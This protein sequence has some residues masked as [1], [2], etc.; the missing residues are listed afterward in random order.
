MTHPFNSKK[1]WVGS[2]VDYRIGDAA[3]KALSEVNDNKYW[4]EGLGSIEVDKERWDQAQKYEL[5]TWM[6]HGTAS[7]DDRD[8]VHIEGFNSYV[9][10]PI[11]LGK[12]VEIG[13][14]P[15]TQS[16][17]IVQ[18]RTVD[19]VTLVDP[20]IL[21]YSKHQNCRYWSFDKKPIMVNSAAEDFT[22]T[23]FD[24]AICI[25]VL[26]HVRDANL[27]MNNLVKCLN[28]G[29]L[30]IFHDRVYDGLDITRIYDIGHPI[31]ITSAFLNP[32]L[33]MFKKVYQNDDYF[34]G[35]KNG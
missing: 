2:P 21:K 14:G 26:E 30:L 27:V 25:N 35:I 32:F 29:G 24:T 19:S 22:E 1:Q 5:D 4:R 31:R 13:C 3:D 18:G 8:H 12:L 16:H 34:I 11:E 10:I 23:G 9:D 7:Q 33:D 28:P 15:F 17:N 6:K 20:L